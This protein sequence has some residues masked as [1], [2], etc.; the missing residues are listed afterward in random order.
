MSDLQ[1]RILSIDDPS[2]IPS[3]LAAMQAE[4]L[5]VF[6][7]DTL[8]GLAGQINETSLHK[9]YAAKQRP[10]EKAIP[11]LVGSLEQIDQLAS[12]VKPEVL[13]LMAAYWPGPLTLVLPKKDGLPPSLSPYPGLAVR[14]PEHAFAL[15]LLQQSGALAVSSANIS[16]GPNPTTAEDVYAQLNGRVALILDGGKHPGGKASTIVDCQ[17]QEP[18]LLREGPIPFEHILN[19][20][21]SA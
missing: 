10:E 6:P 17:S 5:I 18:L 8:Y 7:T 20:W 3:A 19:T 21:R 12:S 2:A 1:T 16:G 11:V 15:N 9:I 14:M 13:A 4:E